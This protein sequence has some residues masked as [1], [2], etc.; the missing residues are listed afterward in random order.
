M[1]AGKI[2]TICTGRYKINKPPAYGVYNP[3]QK[4]SSQGQLLQ[5]D[6]WSHGH[7]VMG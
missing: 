6:L 7:I 2:D 1:V 5:E 3:E 4:L